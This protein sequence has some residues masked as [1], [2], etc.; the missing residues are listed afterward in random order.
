MERI[1]DLD[2]KNTNEQNDSLL[3]MELHHAFHICIQFT[4]FISA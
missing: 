2:M 3:F 1:F 4:L